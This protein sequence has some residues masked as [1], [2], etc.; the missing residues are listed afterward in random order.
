[1]CYELGES[2]VENFKKIYRNYTSTEVA[3]WIKEMQE[4]LDMVI[5]LRYN[6]SNKG[7]YGYD[8]RWCFFDALEG[9]EDFEQG[10]VRCMMILNIYVT[11]VKM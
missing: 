1:M 2:F 7:I 8:M 6:K 11:K 10:K 4:A 9:N 3:S 5:S